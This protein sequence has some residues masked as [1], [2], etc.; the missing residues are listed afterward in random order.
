MSDRTITLPADLAT[1]ARRDLVALAEANGL[2]VAA[3]DTAESLRERLVD[4]QRLRRVEARYAAV[5]AVREA[6]R[7]KVAP[8]PASQAEQA[9]RESLWGLAN[10][11]SRTQGEADNLVHAVDA[12]IPVL[13]AFLKGD[14]SIDREDAV[15]E[16]RSLQ[17]ALD[18]IRQS[19]VDTEKYAAFT[20]GDSARRVEALRATHE[21]KPAAK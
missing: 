7:A 13:A 2:T 10:L 16:V 9:I 14:E 6:R 18:Y 15:A 3:R 4:A 11:F 1:L 8:I 20:M 19:R 5:E 12:A 21:R 17:Y